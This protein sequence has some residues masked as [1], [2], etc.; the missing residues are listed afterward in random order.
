MQHHKTPFH[1][2]LRRRLLDLPEVSTMR[3]LL[4]AMSLPQF[5]PPILD[6][7]LILEDGLPG[8]QGNDPD[9]FFGRL[10]H[11]RTYVR[12]FTDSSLS[13]HPE[14]CILYSQFLRDSA[15]AE[16]FFVNKADYSSLAQSV[17]EFI[18]RR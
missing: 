15:V 9:E 8:P 5:L 14:Y 11:I 6:I 17:W 1:E 3:S 2:S 10:H 7:L 4:A 18:R 12:E 16:H 13:D